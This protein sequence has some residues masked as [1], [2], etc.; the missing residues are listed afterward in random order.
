M[1]AAGASGEFEISL[2][3]NGP[4]ADPLQAT[5]SLPADYALAAEGR[6]AQP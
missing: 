6:A 4:P 2:A 3:P 5:G 1:L